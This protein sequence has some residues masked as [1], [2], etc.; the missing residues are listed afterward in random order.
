MKLQPI[1]PPDTLR[2]LKQG[3]WYRHGIYRANVLTYS[4]LITGLGKEF[5]REEWLAK[6]QANL[7]NLGDEAYVL[8]D[9]AHALTALM[10]EKIKT[11]QHYLKNYLHGHQQG[12]AALLV[13]AEE[14]CGQDFS[15][16]T[17]AELRACFSRFRAR[18]TA[19]AHWLWSMEFLNP[20]IDTYIRER[21]KQWNVTLTEEQVQDF[22]QR[23]AY[24]AKKLPFQE[25]RED[26]LHFGGDD[27][28]LRQLHQKYAWL[29]I[30]TWDGTPFTFAEYRQRVAQLI[31]DREKLVK[32]QTERMLHAHQATQT[33]ASVD[34]AELRELLEVTRELIFL[35]TERIDAFSRSW[36]LIWDLVQEICLR[37]EIP[38]EDLLKLTAEELERGLNGAALPGLAHREQYA[39]L[40]INDVVHG[41]HGSAVNEVRNAISHD[42][43]EQKEVMGQCGYRGIARGIA[44]VLQNDRDLHKLN[45]GDILIANLTNPNYDPVFGKI[46]A[47]VTDEGGI[48]CHSA[49]MAREFKIPCVIGTKIATQVFKDGDLIEVDANKG[50]VRK[51]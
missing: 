9:E 32:E 7:V 43:S 15:A 24:T 35:K 47:V 36:Y 20:A 17:N 44:K 11:D 40:R 33:I 23:I 51:L 25:E 49:I 45:T 28:S 13:L 6:G 29:R 2:T 3:K 27:A 26:L 16:M 38:Y 39:L 5:F 1:L 22:L 46:A 19:L 18:T 31:V 50:T 41:A 30:N 34:D 21:V 8:E 4:V 10:L 48:L 37:L 12:N 42:V 14:L